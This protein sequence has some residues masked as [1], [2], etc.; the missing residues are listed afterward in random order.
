[1]TGSEVPPNTA[2]PEVGPTGPVRRLRTRVVRA[3]S[4]LLLPLIQRVAREHIGGETVDDAMSVAR[5]VAFEKHPCTL[6]FWDTAD[7]VA[8]DVADIYRESVEQLA[9]SG[10]DGYLSIK[11]PAL[12][13]DTEYAVELAASAERRGVRLHCDSHGTEAADPSHAMVQAMIDNVS[14]CDLGTTLPG[15]WSRSLS[16]AEWAIERGLGVRVVKGQWPDPADPKRDMRAGYLEVINRLAGRARQVAVASHDVP[17]VAEAITRLRAGGTPLELE[18][19]YG[20]PSAQALRWAHENHVTVRIY[21]PFGKGF[22][23][24][25]IG[26]LRRNPR[27]ALRVAKG[28]FSIGP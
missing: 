2:P 23:P 28:I 11:P 4:A 9:V 12:G 21:V 15:R 8:R 1:M 14:T 7:Y 24:N 22:I 13:F 25:A 18:L 10:L 5:R 19:I 27:V 6:G 17:L 26:L 3:A 16:D 20:V